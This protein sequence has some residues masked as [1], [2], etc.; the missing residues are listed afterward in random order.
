MTGVLIKIVSSIFYLI[1]GL[2][3]KRILPRG[4]NYHLI[5]YRTIFSI[6]FSLVVIS[7]FSFT[8]YGTG[9][10]DRF[11]EASFKDWVFALAICFFSFYGLYYFTNALKHGRY[12]VVAPFISMAAVFSFVTAYF[13]YDEVV[14]LNAVLSFIFLF[15]ALVYHQFTYL[16]TF[17]LSKE[18]YLCLLCSLFWGVSFVLYPISIKAFG[19]YNFS[20]ILELCVLLS[21]VY[22]TVLKENT[23]KLTLPNKADLKVCF[24]IGLCVAGGNVGA[25]YSLENIPIYLNIIIAVLFEA[26]MILAGLY[27]FKEKLRIRDWVLVAGITVGA[28]LLML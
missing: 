3:W 17:R 2:L 6:L 7:A 26:A 9:E 25:N 4:L 22:L 23:L 12:T 28:V 14:G 18:I 19:V 5:F 21:C 1:S 20:L 27:W 16:K 8:D 11:F 10:L 15:G 13:L 24:W